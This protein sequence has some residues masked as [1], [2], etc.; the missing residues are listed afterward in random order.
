MIRTTRVLAGVLASLVLTPAIAVPISGE[1]GIAG[2]LN[3]Y[4]T[5]TA[6][7]CTMDVA[8]ALDFGGNGYG[9]DGPF[10]VTFATGDF[11]GFTP[12]VSSGTIS[13]FQF[14][15][16]SPSPVDPLWTIGGFSFSLE[17]VTIVDQGP[18]DLVLSGAGTISG[19][20]FDDTSG[21]WSLSADT[22][23]TL[24]FSWSSTTVPVMEPGMAGLL[25]LGLVMLGLSRRRP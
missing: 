12:F 4:C 5:G 23:G 15:P 3:P 18:Q 16:L 13:D 22:A 6:S 19:A 10:L 25:L 7:T 14:D 2:F 24:N 9:T 20:G 11:G 17:S 8:N 1:L 21:L